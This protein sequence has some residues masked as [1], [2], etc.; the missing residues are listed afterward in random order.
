VSEPAWNLADRLPEDGLLGSD[1]MLD[2]FLEWVF[3]HDLE[4]YEAQEE[5]FLELAAGHHV[6]LA[7][8]TGSGKSLVATMLHFKAMCE[9]QRSFYTAPTKALVNEKFFTCCDDFGA[10]EVGMLTG[11]ASINPDAP[12]IC[13]TTEVLANMA[14]RQGTELFA[15][16]VV[17]DEF[18]YYGDRSRGMAWQVPLLVLPNTL[19][20]LM[21]ATLGDTTELSQ[22]IEQRS[23]RE[24]ATIYSEQR[25]VP[26][27]FSYS[28]IPL[29]ETVE[30]LLEEG[31]SPIYVVHFTQREAADQAQALTS[32]QICTREERR[33][34]QKEIGSFAFDTSYGKEFRRFLSFGIGVHHAGLLPRYRLLVEQLAQQGLLKVICGTDT[35][36]VG[37]NI[38]IRTVLFSR[39]F[40][41]DGQ[42]LGI[43]SVR[44]FKQIAGRAGRKGFDD[45][46]SVVCQ[47]PE[48]VIENK[49]IG[50]K[51]T[52]AGGRGKK[53]R[54]KSAP[55]RNFVN[56]SR[57]TM[58]RLIHQMPEPLESRFEVR[59]GLVVSLLQRNPGADAGVA[60]R[61]ILE[62]IELSHEKDGRK[63]RMRRE[64]AQVFRSLR[65]AGIVE[66]RRGLRAGR[67]EVGV[68]DELQEQFSLHHALSLYLV[69]TIEVLDDEVPGYALDVLSLVEAILEDP[70]AVL[71][72][73][74]DRIKGEVV[75]ALKAEGV[76]YEERVRHLEEVSYP[77]PN[78]DFI[79]GTFNR[80]A[81]Q[82]PWVRHESIRPK[83][84]AREIFETYSG[85]NDYVRLN[86]LARSEGVL[87][88][89]LGQV[90]STLFQNVPEWAR[91]D[92]IYDM[93][94]FFRTLFVGVDS[95]LLDEWENRLEARPIIE[96]VEVAE[97]EPPELDLAL[98]AR[99]LR[100]RV[101]AELHRL[102]RALSER[103]WTDAEAAVREQPDDLWDAERFERALAPFYQEYEA[104][105][106]SHRARLA[107]YTQLNP[108]GERRWEAVQ[109]LLDPDDDNLWCIEA[110]VDLTREKDPHGCLLQLR[111]IGT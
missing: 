4:P 41:F 44:E 55:G 105:E 85:F 56:W 87:L 101:R 88:R 80:F 2:H 9:G 5:A 81:E 92:E 90:Y 93:L 68:S 49:R 96:G 51:T 60:Y 109:I 16:Y 34:I 66:L 57:D 43:L 47:A 64:A 8:P 97:P 38:P 48:H 62:L 99:G 17:M 95:S 71:Y 106:F 100:A 39:L 61:S 6:I 13:C 37:V 53:P 107:E 33:N 45:Q 84:I 104:L 52:G 67:F 18:H 79:Y 94:A 14:L 15:P 24:V 76:P 25:P 7:T 22:R 89:Y 27:D 46:G 3:D 30:S 59:H 77:K 72:R 108:L 70:R 98:D 78:A 11:D 103:S 69:E 75:A 42:K 91:T 65:A 31:K 20:L 102:V 19:F 82:H 36:G 74:E 21:S 110:E 29:H 83:G 54:R 50:A 1:A 23:G 111:R 12:V 58:Q 63:R 73:Q 86:G 10:G 32:A 40:K 26:L 35:L 28:E